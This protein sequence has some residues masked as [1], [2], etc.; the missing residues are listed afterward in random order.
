MADW[1]IPIWMICLGIIGQIAFAS[2][3]LVQWVC[4]EIRQ[5][6]H[7]PVA[8]WYL[9]IVGGVILWCYALLRGDPVFILGQS[10]GLV[11]YSRNL[12][13]IHKKNQLN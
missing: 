9:S 5:E 12:W 4:S 7:I 11:V 8:F 3:F 10:T 2:R 13:L 1:N 6:S